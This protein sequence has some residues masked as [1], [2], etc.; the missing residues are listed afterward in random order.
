M[1][2][3][4]LENYLNSLSER[5]WQLIK[6]PSSSTRRHWNSRN[7]WWNTKFYKNNPP[8]DGNVKQI[9]INGGFPEIPYLRNLF[10]VKLV[11]LRFSLVN[12][13]V[14][15]FSSDYA[16][17]SCETIDTLRNNYKD[18]WQIYLEP[19]LNGVINPKPDAYGYPLNFKLIKDATILDLRMNSQSLGIMEKQS[20]I[21]IKNLILSP[22]KEIYK[23]TQLL[24]QKALEVKFDGIAYDSVREPSNINIVGNNLVIFKNDKIKRIT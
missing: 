14:A 2:I 6:D 22:D 1:N 4:D 3:Q 18:S 13:P 5:Q 17:M 10:S 12:K 11:P 7:E 8:N 20:K 15:Y 21:D 23:Q 9:P 19:Y 24:A 16:L